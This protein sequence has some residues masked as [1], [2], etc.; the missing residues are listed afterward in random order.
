MIR[1]PPRSTLF[2][3]TTL[4]R[5]GD[6][7]TAVGPWLEEAET[8]AYRPH[9][10]L[11][12]VRPVKSRELRK[13]SEGVARA[14]GEFG[15]WRVEEFHLMQSTLSPHGAQHSVLATFALQAIKG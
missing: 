8:R 13:V 4:F 9:L 14:S 6:V 3:Y 5:S 10:T 1:R 12:R 2:P 15:S 7:R 11:G